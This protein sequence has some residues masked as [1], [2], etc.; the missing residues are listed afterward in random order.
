MVLDKILVTLGG[1][2]L[3]ASIIWY[4]FLYKRSK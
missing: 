4:F 3:S 2:L 1:L